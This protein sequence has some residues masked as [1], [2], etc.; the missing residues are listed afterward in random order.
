MTSK[1]RKQ[2]DRI[3]QTHIYL[4]EEDYSALKQR[5]D[6]EARS[7]NGQVLYYIRRGLEQDRHEAR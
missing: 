5:A 7:V 6:K 3:K 1:P 2:P 4:A